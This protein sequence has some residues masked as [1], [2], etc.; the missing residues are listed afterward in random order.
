MEDVFSCASLELD[1]DL[2]DSVKMTFSLLK[3]R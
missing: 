3:T 2:F 1:P